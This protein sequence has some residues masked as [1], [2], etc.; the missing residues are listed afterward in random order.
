MDVSPNDSEWHMLEA[1]V[2]SKV[3]AL[4]RATVTAT[5]SVLQ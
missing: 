2:S 5:Y 4:L 3:K 1:R